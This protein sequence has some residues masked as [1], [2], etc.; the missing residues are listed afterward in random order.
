MA[1]KGGTRSFVCLIVSLAAVGLAHAQNPPSQVTVVSENQTDS[2][3]VSEFSRVAMVPLAALAGLVGA[4]LRP[5]SEQGAILSANG[6]MARLTDGRNFVYVG[7][8]LVLLASPPRRVTGQW[9]VPLDFIPKVLPKFAKEPFIY[10]DSERMLIV[11]DAIPDAR[12]SLH[13]RPGV[14][15]GRSFD[16][17]GRADRGVSRPRRRSDSSSRLPI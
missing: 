8:E 5:G 2:I 11:G 13:P 7:Q 1:L 12:G 16:Q 17:P 9:F 15:A 14:H 4:E 3:P 6:A 10:R